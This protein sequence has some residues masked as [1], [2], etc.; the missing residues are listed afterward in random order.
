M[1]TAVNIIKRL[2]MRRPAVIGAGERHQNPFWRIKNI[3]TGAYLKIG[4][5]RGEKPLT[6]RLS[7]VPAGR[8]L[9]RS[10]GYSEV[11]NFSFA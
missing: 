7:D 9:I 1:S 4:K 6:V 10:G 3:D 2:V 8:Y 11:A 5:L